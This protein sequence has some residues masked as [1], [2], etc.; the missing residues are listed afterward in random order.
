MLVG[1]LTAVSQL[2]FVEIDRETWCEFERALL[3]NVWNK[4]QLDATEYS[5]TSANE[6]NSFRNHIR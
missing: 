2:M 1:Y 3:W 4:S 5:D 6:D